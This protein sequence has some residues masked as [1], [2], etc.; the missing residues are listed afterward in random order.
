MAIVNVNYRRWATQKKKTIAYQTIEI[1]HSAVGVLRYVTN[2]QFNKSFTLAVGEPRNSG[3]TVEFEAFGFRVQRPAQNNDPILR[4]DIQLGRVGT[5]IKKKLKAI[6]TAAL[7]ME[8]AELIFR[9]FIDGEQVQR[10]PFEIATITIKDRDVVIRA[11]QANPTFR[12]ISRRYEA[13]DF[14][15]L[16][17]AL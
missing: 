9:I 17:E 8:K 5:E 15:G 16:S 14:I 12:D 1:Y 6:N 13:S 2:Q 10:L 11:E 7:L 3:E 4:L